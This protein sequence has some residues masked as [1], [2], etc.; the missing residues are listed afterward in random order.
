MSNNIELNKNLAVRFMEAIGERDIV[1]IDR[2][3]HPDFVWSVAVIAEDA[4]NE[5]RPLHSPRLQGMK[6]PFDKPRHDRAESLRSLRAQFEGDTTEESGARTV[7]A[8]GSKRKVKIEIH[9]VTAE[10]DRVA[11][12]ASSYISR[13]S[14]G[15]VY[16]NFYHHL[17]VIKDDLI[18]LF[19]EY[20]DTL[21]LL[22]FT[23]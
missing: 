1:A 13:P 18:I 12:E 7:A 23:S 14:D 5:F 16:N 8:L 15:V 17:F 3:M 21:H 20:Q 22:D 6:L 2:L 4:A 11:V 10:E 19:K 9:R